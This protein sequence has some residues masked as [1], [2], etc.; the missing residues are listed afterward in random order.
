MPRSIAVEV[1]AAPVRDTTEAEKVLA[2]LGRDPFGGLV[3]PADAFTVVHHQLFI[4]LAQQ[5]RLPAI[6][7]FV[8]YFL[9]F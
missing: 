1:T 8:C 9:L 3:V 7:L 6:Y 2:K 5:H 4:R